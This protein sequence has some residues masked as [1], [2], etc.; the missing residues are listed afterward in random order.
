[1][2]K[3]LVFLIFSIYNHCFVFG[4]GNVQV[5][6]N[7]WIPVRFPEVEDNFSATQLLQGDAEFSENG[8]IVTVFFNLSI[9]PDRRAISLN[10][11]YRAE[12]TGGDRTIIAGEWNKIVFNAPQGGLFSQI[13]QGRAGST[14]RYLDKNGDADNITY[15]NTG[16]M[17]GDLVESAYIMGDSPGTDIGYSDINDRRAPWKAGVRTIRFK[18]V[19]V[20]LVNDPAYANTY[21]VPAKATKATKAIKV[22]SESKIPREPEVIPSRKDNIE[23]DFLQTV[24]ETEGNT[25]ELKAC[26]DEKR[27]KTIELYD[28]NELKN[29]FKVQKFP[30]KGKCNCYFIETVSLKPG[31]NKFMLGYNGQGSG[32]PVLTIISK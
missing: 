26:L 20:L 1:M 21:P 28:G 5:R 10:V 31:K 8:P 14:I 13:G 32:S 18:Q 2:K 19:E 11:R 25:T 7:E 16:A 15:L 24:I 4:Q 17:T 29:S 12:E 3:I 23:W 30:P 6:V 9:T 22:K 27:I